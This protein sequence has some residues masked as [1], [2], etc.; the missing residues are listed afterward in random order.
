MLEIIR[1]IKTGSPAEVKAAQ[2]Q[3]EKF[4][5]QSCFNKTL[6]QEFLVFMQEAQSFDSIAD[7]YHKACFINTLKWPLLNAESD[8]FQFWS[9]FF[10]RHIQSP[11]GKIR[12]AVVRAS[13]YLLQV[14]ANDFKRQGAPDEIAKS[15][16]AKKYFVQW[17]MRIED[18]ISKYHEKRFNRCKYIDAFPTGIYKSLQQML[19]AQ[20]PSPYFNGIYSEFSACFGIPHG[21]DGFGRA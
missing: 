14:V 5:H 9:E 11:E 4:W 13:E 7:T 19:H 6:R 8:N 18:L 2:K 20:L 1:I 10:L 21:F 16:L 12:I 3:V 17:I 15:H